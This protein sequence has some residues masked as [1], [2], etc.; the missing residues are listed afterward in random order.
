ML[1]GFALGWALYRILHRH[2]SQNPR[3]R[4]SGSGLVI[5]LAVMS[6]SSFMGTRIA[7]ASVRVPITPQNLPMESAVFTFCF[8]GTVDRLTMT[9]PNGRVFVWDTTTEEVVFRV[10][11]AVAGQYWLEIDGEFIE[12]SLTLSDAPV[13]PEGSLPESSPPESH[14]PETSDSTLLSNSEPTD[15]KPTKSTEK[16]STPLSIETQKETKVTNATDTIPA[17]SSEVQSTT[18]RLG[19]WTLLHESS[20]MTG[21]SKETHNSIPEESD[22]PDT[23][24]TD[25]PSQEI[26]NREDLGSSVTWYGIIGGIGVLLGYLYSSKNSH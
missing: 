4:A 20:G 26:A 1:V 9:D 2:R 14:S 8:E 11:D 18:F 16:E 6:L 25:A 13:L 12:F 24:P 3:S 7:A 5:L 23:I 19:E 22:Q 21:E 15:K 10:E 17:R